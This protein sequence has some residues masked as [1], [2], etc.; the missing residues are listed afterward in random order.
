MKKKL[1]SK[2]L[3]FVPMM[4][5]SACGY[6]L[7]EI[8]S[9]TA[10]NSTVFDENFYTV[11]DADLK[12]ENNKIS[13][14][15]SIDLDLEKDYVFETFKDPN[16]EYVEKNHNDNYIYE[17]EVFMEDDETRKSFGEEMKLSKIDSSFKYGYISKLF[18]G[19]MFCDGNYQ[20]A[21]V[22]INENGFGKM[23]NKEVK[24]FDYFA[25]NFKSSLDYTVHPFN[26]TK[27]NIDLHITFYM[28]NSDN[29]L[30]AVTVNYNIDTVPTNTGD[31]HS[32]SCYTF[33]GFKFDS[34]RINIERCTGISVT[35]DLNDVTGT[36]R[37]NGE[38]K[39]LT[40]EQIKSEGISHSLMIYEVFLPNS[41]WH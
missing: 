16:F 4:A 11:W 10:Y 26:S 6:S 25:M 35:Y 23:F 5:L 24:Q 29:K 3:L 7:R 21:R 38:T 18:D 33:F 15:K 14:K 28:K 20:K 8:Y 34:T 22:Q 31:S 40:L 2:A 13:S 17:D 19:K 30:D 37:E 36:Y 41:T 32:E 39:T 27:S 12:E 1:L 9:G